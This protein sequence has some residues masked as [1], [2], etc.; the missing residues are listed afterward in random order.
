MHWVA[1]SSVQFWRHAHMWC[2]NRLCFWGLHFISYFSVFN[3]AN[4]VIIEKE[5][6]RYKI[7][8]K[9]GRLVTFRS[10]NYLLLEIATAR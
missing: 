7:S 2:V 6:T 1:G 5:N 4:I 9:V 8:N 3:L 10:Q